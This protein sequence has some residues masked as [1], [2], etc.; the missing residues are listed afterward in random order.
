MAEHC[1]ALYKPLRLSEQEMADNF[2]DTVYAIETQVA[3]FNSVGKFLLSKFVRDN[4]YKVVLTGEGS[5][6]VFAGYSFFLRDHFKAPCTAFSDPN[7]SE[8]RVRFDTLH[9][10]NIGTDHEIYS[11]KNCLLHISNN[12]FQ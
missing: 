7:L 3:N 9:Y 2:A 1:G 11:V 6:E 8:A 10:S 4:G 5:D 12:R